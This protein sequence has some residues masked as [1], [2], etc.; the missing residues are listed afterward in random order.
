MFF[1]TIDKQSKNSYALYVIDDIEKPYRVA[2]IFITKDMQKKNPTLKDVA[3]LAGVSTATVARVL[4]SNGYIADET[5]TRVE[6]AIHQ[7]GYRINSVAR[8][9][10]IQRTASIGHILNCILPNPFFAGVALGA[11]QEALGNGWSILMINVQGDAQRERLGVE[12]FIHQRMDAILFTTPVS[13]ANIHLALDAG[14]PVV[15][16]ERS[17]SIDTYA[18]VVDNYSGSAQAVEHLIAHGHQRIAFMGGDPSVRSVDK[19]FGRYIEEERLAA[20][21]DTLNK[22]H[23]PIDERLIL[24]GQYYSMDD[25]FLSEVCIPLKHLL[26]SDHRPTAV[27]A[28]SDMLASWVLQ[29]LYACGLR[30][31]EDVS[32]IGF[33]DTIARYLSPPLTTVQQPMLDIGKAAVRLALQH[34]QEEETSDLQICQ[35]VKLPTSLV[36]RSSTGPAS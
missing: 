34:F 29:E 2:R 20:Y 23:I 26:R 19:A 36:I 12:T 35:Q 16:V 24:L 3:R 7:A 9:L 1:R 31:P 5:K 8:N 11:E 17:T 30:I 22:H 6:A 32:V 18:V 28:T 15:Q 33:D 14:I 10:R 27:F 25:P 13:E 21:R 4:H